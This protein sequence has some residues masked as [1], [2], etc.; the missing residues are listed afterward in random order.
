MPNQNDWARMII[1]PDNN[2]L[3]ELLRKQN[4]RNA[5][6]DQ[7]G[8]IKKA[9]D[10]KEEHWIIAKIIESSI[11]TIVAL[12]VGGVAGFVVGYLLGKTNQSPPPAQ[13]KNQQTDSLSKPL[14]SNL[15]TP[16]HLFLLK[17]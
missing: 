10:W 14:T 12:I 17:P 8:R 9:K 13:Q 3:P 7:E 15:Y 2:I 11:N 6:T 16:S 5:Q 1:N 4:E